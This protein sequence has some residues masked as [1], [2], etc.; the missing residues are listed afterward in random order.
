MPAFFS[1]MTFP[2]TLLLQCLALILGSA[3]FAQSFPHLQF[4]EF[5]GTPGDE[6]PHAIV[7][8]EDGHIVMGGNVSNTESSG[9]NNEN[10]WLIKVDKKGEVIWGKEI[11]IDGVQQLRGLSATEDGSVIFTGVSGSMIQHPETGD[12]EYWGDFIAGKMDSTGALAWV[13]TFGGSNLDQ[14]R[15][16]VAERYRSFAIVGGTHSQDEPIENASGLSDVWL[17]K[18]DTKGNTRY[19]KNW[20]GSGNDWGNAIALCRNDD[21]LMAG[22]TNS[23]DLA[24]DSKPSRLGNGIVIRVKTTGTTVWEKSF[25][26]PMGGYFTDV[27]EDLNGN[28][29]IAGNYMTRDKGMQFWSVKLDAD[30][31]K[32]Y[33]RKW[34]GVN[35]EY[36]T[37]VTI[38]ADS[39]YLFSGYS[40]FKGRA[41]ELDK[42]LKGKD[43]FWLIRT[44]PQGQIVWQKTYGGPDN[45]RGMDVL[46]YEP[47]LFFALGQKHNDLNAD[48][49]SNGIDF[50]LLRLKDIPC[51]SI[52]A[53]I[54][55]RAPEYTVRKGSN[56]RFRAR[57]KYAERFLWEFGDGTTSTEEQPLK[58]FEIPGMYQVKLTI[59][60]NEN[61]SQ[62]VKLPELLEVW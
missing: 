22:F 47:G 48:K 30:G 17:L 14:A 62:S 24:E 50:W 34:G 44:D 60:I 52:N 51:D 25:K 56:V 4:Q 54:F 9:P 46:Q 38:C 39:G 28:V 26:A 57:Y 58:V 12:E 2:K 43:D 23:Q 16:I 36:L 13:E 7:K 49:T 21:L 10:I 41:K 15:D 33:E 45:E 1:S 37:S 18:L 53:D 42:Y 20:G 27:K 40:R 11:D 5:Y 19:S 32:L 61:C 6:V 29:I 59:F 35:N 31:K 8:T 3:C 55:V